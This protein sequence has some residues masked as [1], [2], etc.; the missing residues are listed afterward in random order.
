MT[1]G[2][3]EKEVPRC[4]KVTEDDKKTNEK[5]EKVFGSE[6]K[7]KIKRAL[8]EEKREARALLLAAPRLS[9]LSSAFI[10]NILVLGLSALAP[11]TPVPM[12]GLSALTSTSTV[13][14]PLPRST[15]SLS[16]FTILMPVPRLS[17]PPSAAPVP[18]FR[19]SA[20]LSTFIIPIPL[21]GLSA[22]LS[23]SAISVSVPR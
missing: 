17:V 10:S 22:P 18:V 14:V 9:A 13:R 5:A 19:S 21:P 8:Y 11:T 16:T 15:A 20:S 12:P 23:T 2:Y 1:I 6:E 4:T 3:L 7:I